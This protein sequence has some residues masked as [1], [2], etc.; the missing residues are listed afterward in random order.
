M[1]N[2]PRRFQNGWLVGVPRSLG[3]VGLARLA[4]GGVVTLARLAR[5]RRP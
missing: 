3:T 5:T 2:Q 1:G 4:V